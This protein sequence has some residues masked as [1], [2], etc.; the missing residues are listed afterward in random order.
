M[1]CSLTLTLDPPYVQPR[2]LPI[3]LHNVHLDR[4][5][6]NTVDYFNRMTLQKSK[7]RKRALREY[8]LRK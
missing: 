8:L 1:D 3:D 7:G 6:A 5:V 2:S 4:S